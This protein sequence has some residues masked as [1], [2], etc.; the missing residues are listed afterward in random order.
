ML[1]DLGANTLGA[2]IGVRLAAASRPCGCSPVA[3]VGGLTLASERVSFTRVIAACRRCAGSTSSGGRADVGDRGAS[4]PRSCGPPSVGA[5]LVR[6]AALIAAIT[7][8]PASAGFLR[9][10]VFARTVGSSCVGVVY[11]TANTIPNIVFD[12]VA[13]GTLA[14]LV[15]PLVAP[16]LAA[17]IDRGAGRTVS[18]LLTWAVVGLCVVGAPGHRVRRPDHPAAARAAAVCGR[19]RPGPADADRLRAAGGALRHGRRA[20]RDLAGGRTVQLA[21]ARPACVERGRHRRLPHL[22]RRRERQRL[23]VTLPTVGRA[24]AERRHDAGVLVLA[25]CQL[26]AVLRLRFASADLAVPEPASRRSP[27]GPQSPAASPWP[28]SN[29]HRGHAAAGQ[30][31]HT[32]HLVVLTIAQTVYLVPV[33]RARRAGRDRV[34]PADVIGLGSGRSRPGRRDRRHRVAGD[35]RAGRARHGGAGRGGDAD[36]ERAA[37]RPQRRPFGVR[38]GDRGL[39]GRSARLVSSSRYCRVCSTPLADRSWPRPARRSAG[40]SRSSSI[41]RSRCRSIATT[42]RSCSRSAMPPA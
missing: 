16:P 13:G 23:G 31:R 5:P 8:W 19:R 17:A 18:A 27:G 35:P 3:V 39:R 20:G 25:G 10:S 11:Q 30:R 36:R 7:V 6:A 24:G 4:R 14:A 28:L 21:G 12:I 9:T 42:G 32:R 40:W 26:P 38:P 41:W 22:R 29:W 34:V 15:V 37:R 1:G 2:L 33:G